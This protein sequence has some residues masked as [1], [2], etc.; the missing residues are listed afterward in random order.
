MSTNY[1]RDA[2]ILLLFCGSIAFAGLAHAEDGFN[3]RLTALRSGENT[4]TLTC[5]DNAGIAPSPDPQFFRNR[6]MPVDGTREAG[7]QLTFEITREDVPLPT[8]TH[9][10]VQQP[11][12]EVQLDC[13][14]DPGRLIQQ[15]FVTWYKSNDIIYETNSNGVVTT[16]LD[17]ERYSHNPSNL[18]LIINDIEVDDTSDNYHCVLGVVNPLS[19]ETDHYDVLRTINIPLRVLGKY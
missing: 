3:F 18:A 2:V 8:T 6:T 14:I 1:S 9:A 17:P 7:N 13:T 5:T 15:Y 10:V 16:N 19:G 12:E 11:P 4:I